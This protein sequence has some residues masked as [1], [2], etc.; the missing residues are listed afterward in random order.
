MYAATC[1]AASCKDSLGMVNVAWRK[2]VVSE[3]LYFSVFWMQYVRQ[4]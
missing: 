1:V 2:Y 4:R 3:T